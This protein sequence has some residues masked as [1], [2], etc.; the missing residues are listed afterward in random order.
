[1]RRI[2]RAAWTI[3]MAAIL[4]GS[5]VSA[6]DW[7]GQGR[8]EGAVKDAT[9]KPIEGATVSMRWTDGKGPDIKT[10]KKGSFAFLGLNGG[11]WS[12]DISAPGFQTKKIAYNVSQL[13]RNPSMNVSLE[14]EVKQEKHEE[15][16][17]IGGQKVS[18]DTAEAIKAANEAWAASDW[19][20][21]GANY[22]KALV[23]LPDNAS[24]LEH[25][26]IAAYN[27]KK[28]DVAAG[29][30]KKIV[31]ADP[32]NSTSLLIIAETEL[33]AGHLDAG[34]AALEKVPDEKIT[35]PGPYL[36]LGIN[37][38]NKNQ[39]AEAEKW[40]TKA[41]EKKGDAPDAY[42]Y[43]GLARFNLKKNADAKADLAKYLELAPDGPNAD[44][45][46]EIIKAMAPAKTRHG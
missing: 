23:E 27:R 42:Y 28:F 9:G 26:E 39:P 33:Q 12:V 19:E 3:G 2:G 29:F 16:F 4:A 15:A 36:N 6:Q 43:R 21:A 41:I 22:E 20:K 18:K 35:D 5:L 44:T 25:A 37:Y 11:E 24:L 38:Y 1:M 40:F 31:A 10:N 30:A 32:G 13:A 34:R 14:P 17:E 8:V 7:R 45:A 46:K